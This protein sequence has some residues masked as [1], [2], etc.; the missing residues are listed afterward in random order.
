ME[1]EH[2]NTAKAAE[3]VGLRAVSEANSSTTC[4]IRMADMLAGVISKLL[5]ALNSSLHSTSPKEQINKKILDKSWF[6]VNERQLS[7]YKRMHQIAFELIKAWYKT[8]AGTYSDDLIV[9]VAFLKFM[10]RFE[11]IED[12]KRNLD[13]QGEYFNNYACDS[14][15]AYYVRMQ[16][17]LPIEPVGDISKDYFLNQRN[18]KVYFDISKQPML[19]IKDNQRIC[20]VLSVGFSKDM[21]PMIAITEGNETKC[22][23]IPTALSEWALTLVGLANMGENLFPAKVVFTKAKGRY[24]ADIL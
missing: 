23:R 19:E 8:Y 4:G 17:K 6:A 10:N 5:K 12:I 14:L 7:L 16:N 18:A 9:L 24:F 11:T 1:G 3:Q 15:V 13:I 20:D 2:G 22:Y 21:I